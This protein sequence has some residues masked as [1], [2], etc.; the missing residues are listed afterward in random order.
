MAGANE[1]SPFT[2][3]ELIDI[4]N[5]LMTNDGGGF[6]DLSLSDTMYAGVFLKM[7]TDNIF[8][9]FINGNFAAVSPVLLYRSYRCPRVGTMYLSRMTSPWALT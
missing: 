8:V 6:A 3:F 7:F 2:Q 5:S 1:T 9:S 4:S